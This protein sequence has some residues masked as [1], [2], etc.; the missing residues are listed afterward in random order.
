MGVKTKDM[1]ANEIL[2]VIGSST[3]C[4]SECQKGAHVGLIAT[5]G[6]LYPTTHAQAKRFRTFDVLS[7]VDVAKIESLLNK[8]GFCGNYKLTKSKT[9]CRLQNID[10]FK[11]ALRKEY[12]F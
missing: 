8:H 6:R 1:K 7:G 5:I 11:S 12:N 4:L 3:E 2:Q 9:W 10:D